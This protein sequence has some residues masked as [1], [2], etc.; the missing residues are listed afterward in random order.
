MTQFMTLLDFVC[1]KPLPSEDDGR[2]RRL[3]LAIAALGAAVL[4]STLWGVAAGSRFAHLA[5]ANAYKVP[6]MVVVSAVT[7]V[8]AGLLAWKLLGAAGR[9]TELLLAFASSVLAGALVLGVTAPIVA[10]YYHSSSWAGPFIGQGSVILALVVGLAVFVRRVWRMAPQ[11]RRS[12]LAMFVLPVVQGATLLQ[13]IALHRPILPERTMFDR[14]I[15]PIG[16]P[17]P[18]N[19]GGK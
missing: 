14:G 15:E 3:Q 5:I 16:A 18:A 13:L 4:L 19:V 17:N 2:A 12:F 11:R 9:A 7:A 8:P 1:G 10:L 6:V